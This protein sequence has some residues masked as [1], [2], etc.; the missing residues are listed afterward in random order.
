MSGRE[1]CRSTRSRRLRFVTYP[2]DDVM[3]RAIMTCLMHQVTLTRSEGR[4]ESADV[5]C[6]VS[7]MVNLCLSDEHGH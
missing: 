2:W 4:S 6:L 7:A 1:E 5:N 3:L